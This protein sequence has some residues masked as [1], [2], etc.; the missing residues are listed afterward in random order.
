MMIVDSKEFRV[1]P[2]CSIG[3]RLKAFTLSGSR[4]CGL[5]MYR[6][7]RLFVHPSMLGQK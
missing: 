3:L 7:I 1:S 5:L 4:H 6:G 2:G